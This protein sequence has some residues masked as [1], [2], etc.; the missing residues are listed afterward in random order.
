MMGRITGDQYF[1]AGKV[2]EEKRQWAVDYAK[3][4]F[5]DQDI[6][7]CTGYRENL[8][9]WQPLGGFDKTVE[10]GD[11]RHHQLEYYKG[12]P[13]NKLDLVYWRIM[14]S[15]AF[16]LCPGGDG[17]WSMRT[18]EAALAGTI[19][20]IKSHDE[21]W[22][23]TNSTYHHTALQKVFDLF[24]YELTSDPHVFNQSVADENLRIFIRYL[25]FIE[26]DNTPP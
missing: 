25:T 21:D 1:E 10:L 13:E 4:T 16:T 15:S 22:Q 14:M 18:Y 6:F 3:A 19:C 17:A 11:R 24:K 5:T 7:V 9:K 23:A 8:A 2:E 20:V 12:C 26:G